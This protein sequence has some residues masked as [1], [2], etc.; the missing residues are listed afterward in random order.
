MSRHAWRHV[1]RL[2][3]LVGQTSFPID[4]FVS[5][6]YPDGKTWLRS[7]KLK[8][9]SF[10]LPTIGNLRYFNPQN[11]KVARDLRRLSRELARASFRQV[12]S[13]FQPNKSQNLDLKSFFVKGEYSDRFWQGF[14]LPV[15]ATICTCKE[16]LLYKWPATDLLGLAKEVM[17]GED[18]R[19]LTKGTKGLVDALSSELNFV[20]G[21]PVCHLEKTDDGK[22]WVAN[23]RGDK[24]LF[25]RVVFATQANQLEFIRKCGFDEELD[26]LANFDYDSGEL[27]VHSDES[28]MPK[29]RSDWTALNYITERDFS[30]SIFSVW[31]NAVEPSLKNYPKPIF[32]SWNAPVKA[33]SIIQ[34]VKL[35]RAVVNAKNQQALERLKQL[36]RKPDRSV[37]FCG[38]WAAPG[39]PLLES[40]PTFGYRSSGCFK[41]TRG[42]FKR[43]R[44][45][46]Q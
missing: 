4:T 36:H 8:L 28:F 45:C 31:V 7:S 13:M 15:L 27:V 17:L 30:R 32:Q 18:L 16:E 34:S 11:I 10:E 35:E 37:F 20:S 41:D 43:Y 23:A 22:W 42:F 12:G 46:Y 44:A 1:L 5:Y 26:L 6:S 19:R 21:S 38:S 33:S 24:D 3:Q 2:C 25:D 29:R 39:T 40:A 14:L 9:G